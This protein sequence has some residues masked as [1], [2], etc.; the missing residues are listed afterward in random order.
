MPLLDS[1]TLT[2]DVNPENTPSANLETENSSESP[3]N[4]S[5]PANVSSPMGQKLADNGSLLPA[6]EDLSVEESQSALTG[7]DNIGRK[8]PLLS[9]SSETAERNIDSQPEK[10]SEEK[11]E[12]DDRQTQ[13]N[14]SEESDVA[15]QQNQSGPR[16]YDA[17]I[18][19][20]NSSETPQKEGSKASS[21]LLEEA[22][23]L[24]D[25]K[26]EKKFKSDPNA[27]TFSQSASKTQPSQTH[28]NSPLQTLSSSKKEEAFLESD[29]AQT[30]VSKTQ[31]EDVDLLKQ[32]QRN[33]EKIPAPSRRESKA[34]LATSSS[35]N[36]SLGS[37]E[38]SITPSSNPTSPVK[39]FDKVPSPSQNLLLKSPRT[40]KKKGTSQGQL[41]K[42]TSSFNP[43]L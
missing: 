3:E 23:I 28:G 15:I 27:Q 34:E 16:D 24:K 4:I 14:P 10:S 6:D 39:S 1:K 42:E 38:K 35:R 40:S 11:R 12:L 36:Q 31:A 8:P 26:A 13:S 5:L 18:G 2:T 17:N 20:T 22:K 25:P 33:V 32:T 7:S 9:N 37:P 29:P 19:D 21:P 43:L 30:P 41:K